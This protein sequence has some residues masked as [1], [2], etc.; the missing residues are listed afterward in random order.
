MKKNNQNL[1]DFLIV[2]V[3][4]CGT[5]SLVKY[6]ENHP[7]ILFS[8]KKEPR[9][10]TYDLLSEKG[11][12]GPGDFRPKKIAVKSLN[13][14]K[15]QFLYMPSKTKGEAS[16][17]TIF[18]YKHS[19]PK[20][21]KEIGDPKIIIILRDPVRRA[22]SAYS[23]LVREDRE[24]LDFKEALKNE[25]K[26]LSN[27]FECIWAYAEGGLYFEPVKAFIHAFKNVK[28]IIFENFIAEGDKEIGEILDF[29]SL[30]KEFNFEKVKF[31]KSGRP[32]SRIINKFLTRKS[33]VKTVISFLIGKQTA[34][35]IK[36]KVQERNLEKIH[37][38]IET[39]K[40]LYNYFKN[41]ITKLESFLN[42]NLEVWKKP[43]K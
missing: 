29:L 2:G 18:Y 25:K 41:D 8:K 38:G 40:E 7:E 15:A 33:L 16:T 22:I 35:T 12:K 30:S 20:I 21:K 28:V 4:K 43:Y 34:L 1:P 32:K 13:D 26:R 39:Q 36:N 37:I 24:K 42:I 19:I 11:Y 9:Y 23:H 14:Y 6:L 3:A 10:L 31:N 27:G 5:T 17:D